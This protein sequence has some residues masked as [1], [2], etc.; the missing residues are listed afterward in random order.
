[1]SCINKNLMEYQV[2][3]NRS[4]IP[5]NTLDNYC[6]AFLAKYD[7]FPYLDELPGNSTQHLIETLKINNNGFTSKEA[8]LEF[9]QS[10]EDQ[11]N[12][13]IND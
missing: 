3:L 8:V 5:E 9:T 7:R 1:M 10:S 11:V 2:L 6:R 13:V 4:G 12:T